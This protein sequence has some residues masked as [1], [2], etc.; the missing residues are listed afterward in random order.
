[1]AVG[2]VMNELTDRP[3]TRPIG[4]IHL[5]IVQSG[6]G[7]AQS[8]GE[9]GDVGDQTPPHG[10]VRLHRREAA[11]RISQIRVGDCHA[12]LVQ[13]RALEMGAV[14]FFSMPLVVAEGTVRDQIFDQTF[15][16]WGEGLTRE[17]YGQWNESQLKTAW[18]GARLQRF[19]F[20]GDRGELLASAKRYRHDIRLN[21]RDGWMA[22]FGAVFAPETV[23][24]R[25][26]ATRLL[27]MLIEREQADGA[28]LASLFSEIGTAFYE[29]IGFRAVPLDEVTI[30]VKR[31]DGA[32]AM[33]V[34][35]GE[36]RDLKNLA[37]MHESRAVRA[38]FA[39][40]RDPASIAYALTKKRLLAGLSPPGLRQLEFFVA[41]EG[42]SAVAYVVLSANVNGWTL[43]EAGDRD[44][45][46]ARLG[47]ML[48]VLVAREPAHR[49]PLIRAWWPRTMPV[50]PQ[51]ELADRTD[52]R[53]VFMVKPLADVQVP[54]NADDVFYWR[55]DYF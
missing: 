6:G 13:R 42:S 4:C 15:A 2:N 47:A 24:G 53:D 20:V 21:G 11:D 29:R 50:P 22:G 18:G 8:S 7:L 44:P 46:G 36:E 14:Q 52:S 39:L 49:T 9:R 55:S 19:A 27:E 54:T 45:A 3:S 30:R 26:H 17:A 37:A 38:R 51:I 5:P 31:R 32:P 40:R 16:I 35:S 12:S 34:R 10:R 23:R 41:E 48:Q 33:L 1:M 28:L 25:G 43:E